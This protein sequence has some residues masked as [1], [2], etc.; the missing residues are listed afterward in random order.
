MAISGYDSLIHVASGGLSGATC[1]MI[2]MPFDVVRKRM[3]VQH[4]ESV[5]YV[6]HVHRMA[7]LWDCVQ[8]TYVREGIRGFYK[9]VLPAVVKTAPASAATFFAF[10]MVKK[11]VLV[12]RE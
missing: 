4:V 12:V 3:Q 8:K 10:E 6:T 11:A 5:H 7:G 9:G 2:M 1:K